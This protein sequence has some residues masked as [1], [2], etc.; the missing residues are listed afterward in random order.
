MSDDH[1]HEPFREPAAAMRGQDEN[2]RDPGKSGIVGD[3]ARE[4]NLLGALVHA[5]RERVLD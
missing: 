2:I 3:D 4:A 1:F 5:E